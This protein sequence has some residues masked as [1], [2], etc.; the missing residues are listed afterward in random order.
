[1]AVP[2]PTADHAVQ[3]VH[4]QRRR[5]ADDLR[6]MRSSDARAALPES[7]DV[8]LAVEMWPDIVDATGRLKHHRCMSLLEPLLAMLSSGPKSARKNGSK[9][10]TPFIPVN[11]RRLQN[12]RAC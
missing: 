2:A 4:E 3:E 12:S 8:Q 6:Q 10:C 5:R 11:K 7:C 1:M 9:A